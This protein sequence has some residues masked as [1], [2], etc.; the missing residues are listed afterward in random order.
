MVDMASHKYAILKFFGYAI[1]VIEKD[2]IL[3][4]GCAIG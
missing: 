2:F 1:W 4:Y 3:L